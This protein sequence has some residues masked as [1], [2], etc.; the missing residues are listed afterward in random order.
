MSNGNRDKASQITLVTGGAGAIGSNLV[1]ELLARDHCVIVVDNFSSGKKWNLPEHPNLVLVE[2]DICSDDVL[3]CAF[4]YAPSVVFHLA[5]FF[6]NQNSI[7]HPFDDLRT[8]GI[9]I[10]KVL[11]YSRKH[12]VTRFVYSSSSCIYGN[13]ASSSFDETLRT[14]LETPYAITK[15][16]GEHYVL[17]YHKYH[18]LP[19]VVL[20]Y[21]NS[22]GPGEA[23]GKY[24]NVI[25]NFVYQALHGQPLIVFGTGEETRAFTYVSD[26][27]AGT[28]RA[29]ESK[30]AIGEILN[31]GSEQE[32]TINELARLINQVCENRASIRFGPVRNWDQTKRRRPNIRKAREILGFQPLVDIETGVDR[33]VKWMR[34]NMHRIEA[35]MGERIP[36]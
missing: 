29:A 14:R 25:P 31:I 35:E 30:A 24:R 8:N 28:I 18:R 17:F 11:E 20:R 33:T 27:V 9:G 36:V 21:F 32:V 5:A 6:A 2:G 13:A 16:L 3:N 34:D 22:Y 1:R 7:E 10:L 12:G 23:P 4:G 15:L 26:I 19:G